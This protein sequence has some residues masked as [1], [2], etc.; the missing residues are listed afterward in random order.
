[1]CRPPFR[2]LADPIADLRQTLSDPLPDPCRPPAQTDPIPH[3]GY[4]PPLAG[5]RPRKSA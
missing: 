4:A 5:L 1:M 3:K 2:P